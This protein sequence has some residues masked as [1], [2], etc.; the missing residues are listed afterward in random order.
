MTGSKLSFNAYF[1]KN[2]NRYK[3]EE[4]VVSKGQIGWIQFD[5]IVFAYS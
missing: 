4:F 2:A 5:L 1:P 3:S